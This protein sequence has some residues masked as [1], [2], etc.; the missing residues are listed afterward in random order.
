MLHYY[1]RRERSAARFMGDDASDARALEMVDS[2]DTLRQRDATADIMLPCR[3]DAAPPLRH[4]QSATAA[5]SIRHTLMPSMRDAAAAIRRYAAI[6]DMPPLRGCYVA[7][8]RYADAAIRVKMI[9]N[10]STYAYAP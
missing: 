5:D 3:H 9:I 7:A 6:R 4:C 1:R 10:T 2:V 8:R